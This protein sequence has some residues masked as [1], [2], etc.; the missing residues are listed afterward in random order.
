MDRIGQIIGNYR[1]ERLLGRGGMGEVC[2]ARHTTLGRM[3]AIKVL[4][5]QYSDHEQ[6]LARFFNEARIITT[7]EHPGIVQV[8]D[9]GHD[10]R[11]CAYIVMELLQGETLLARLARSGSLEL[12]FALRITRQVANAL[13]AVH[14]YGVV[15]RDLKPDNIF[16][17]EDPDVEGGE[18]A[19]VLDFGIAK[20]AREDASDVHTR[21]GS[22][23]GTP[24]YMSPEQ[25]RGLDNVDY[26]ADIYSLACVLYHLICGRPP[27]E[28]RG[29]GNLIMAHVT[30]SPRRPGALVPGVPRHVDDAIVKALA[31]EPD[32]RFLAMSQFV[33]CLTLDGSVCE[34][35]PRRAARGARPQA[36][37]PALP[38]SSPTVHT[39]LGGTASQLG[40]ARASARRY[41]PG[42]RLFGFIAALAAVTVA[43]VAAGLTSMDG[44]ESGADS[45]WERAPAE[46]P[47]TSA[48]AA[49]VGSTPDA[50][51]ARDAGAVAVEQTV[52]GTQDVQA[53]PAPATRKRPRRSRRGGR[54]PDKRNQKKATQ[55][56]KGGPGKGEA[57]E[58][59]QGGLV[60]EEVLYDP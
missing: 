1:I 7:L 19:K 9:F 11:G 12:G 2:A 6:T 41:R 40:R 55:T 53:A 25:C 49:V 38:V 22:I 8:F 39:T 34:L 51:P 13:S 50:G 44:R 47:A 15:H 59:S 31:K 17:V 30:E 29:T 18:R 48:P 45:I 3:A 5:K 27:F 37:E 20:V 54:R 16:L 35:A 33:E 14:R 10:E 42:G 21:T 28:V 36:G 58:A 26:R 57:V 60:E 56:K 4:Q 23:L 24:R 46:R 43:L 52:E 32:S